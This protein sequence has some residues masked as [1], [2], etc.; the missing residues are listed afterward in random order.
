MLQIL[1]YGGGGTHTTRKEV[2]LSRMGERNGQIVDALKQGAILM[3]LYVRWI[4]LP[5]F[6]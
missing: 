1:S 3:G 4:A 6:G 5:K 2:L